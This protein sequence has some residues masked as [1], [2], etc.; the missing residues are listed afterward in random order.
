MRT[1][2]LRHFLMAFPILEPGL[3]LSCLMLGACMPSPMAVLFLPGVSPTTEE[4]VASSKKD[5]QHQR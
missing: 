4:Q 5:P 2:G 1:E 3:N